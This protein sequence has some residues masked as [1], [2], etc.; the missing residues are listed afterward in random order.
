MTLP[1]IRATD[2]L[3]DTAYEMAIAGWG[4]WVVTQASQTPV[5]NPEMMIASTALIHGFN[6]MLSYAGFD[7]I[8]KRR[9]NFLSPMLSTA[10]ISGLCLY[11]IPHVHN[12]TLSPDAKFTLICSI[13]MAAMTKGLTR[14]VISVEPRG[15]YN[16]KIQTPSVFPSLKPLVVDLPCAVASKVQSLYESVRDSQTVKAVSHKIYWSWMTFRGNPWNVAKPETKE[17]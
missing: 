10:F 17:L 9:A 3:N 16:E 7:G 13:A 1:E 2:I 6:P 11:T 8:F 14:K 4:A 12:I 5:R 15:R